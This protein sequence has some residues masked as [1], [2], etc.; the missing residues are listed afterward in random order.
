MKKNKAPLAEKPVQ[1]H[2]LA[3]RA[4]S[5]AVKLAI[6]D[7]APARVAVIDNP[8][9]VELVA[10]RDFAIVPKQ[11]TIASLAPK[12]RQAVVCSINGAYI[13]RSEWN[14]LV[15]PG[16]IVLFQVLP[17][18]GKG[19][20]SNP[21]RAILQIGLMIGVAW[22]VGP[23]ALGLTGLT[24]QLATAGLMA[25]GS[26]L[27]NKLVPLPKA[28]AAADGT[29]ASPTYSVAMQGNS[30]RIDSPKPVMYGLNKSFPDQAIPPYYEFVGNEQ[31]LKTALFV[32]M[33]RFDIREVMID[34]TPISN[35]SDINMLIVGPGRLSLDTQQILD[36]RMISSPE[37]SGQEVRDTVNWIG[38]FTVCNPGYKLAKLF[39]DLSA[40]RGIG[41]AKDD[42]TLEI[43]YIEFQVQCQKV[44]NQGKA[45][46][47]W[48]DLRDAN[49]QNYRLTGATAS[50]VQQS[51]EF[52]FPEFA[53][54]QVRL[55]RVTP[56]VDST[57]E[58]TEL[59]WVGMRSQMTKPGIV[60][61]ADPLGTYILL[62]IRAS[63]QLSGL[64]SR[65]ISVISERK[66]Q[67]HDGNGWVWL[68]DSPHHRYAAWAI[69]D[70]LRN[71]HYGNGLPDSKIDMESIRA[72]ATSNALRQDR[73]DYI[74]DVR[75]TI[76]DAV[77]L[78]ARTSR[79]VPISR[80]ATYSFVR[81]EK[82]D[83][84][85]AMFNP[86]NIERGSLSM[87]FTF[88]D[89]DPEDAVRVTYRDLS[90]F[91]P[92]TVVAQYHDGVV[93]AYLQDDRPSALPAPKKYAN[94]QFP[95]ISGYIHACREAIYIV[96][97]GRWRRQ[98][99]TFSTDSEGM[100]PAFGSLIVL[101]H[102]L[103]RTA[104]HA[105]V[106]EYDPATKTLQTSQAMKWTDGAQ[107]YVRLSTKTGGLTNFIAVAKGAANDMMVLSQEP[108]FTVVDMRH[109][110]KL[111]TKMM[112]GPSNTKESSLRVTG[113]RHK[114]ENSIELMNLVEDDRVHDADLALLPVN[115]APQD[116]VE[117]GML[118]AAVLP[119]NNV[120]M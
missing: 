38:P 33:G 118:Q 69:C 28:G 101:L 119:A 1:L 90:T 52:T 46:G 44:N 89:E 39:L 5:V 17:H 9:A 45:I 94:V 56:Y 72:L 21:L 58:L 57:R 71:P 7:F 88:A 3:P 23:A 62:S 81:D 79:A 47:D 34:D 49:N 95:G 60:E 43:R 63:K 24:A 27:I 74:F 65:R 75:S 11:A 25:L 59:S 18:G 106:Y 114:G 97:N 15:R 115:G 55:K 41:Y 53:R 77:A 91:A 68:A 64:S 66:I 12:T 103:P 100:L 19:G 30:A 37:V 98:T 42:G 22:L 99:R 85:V 87:G 117:Y 84:P 51:F 82:Q 111:P 67:M 105:D 112:F 116:L 10:R 4:V 13:S 83:A 93:H 26:L 92:V 76:W 36:L 14:T 20:G 48:I 6:A 110:T 78:A 16:E 96:A 104:Q 54:Y 107:H 113:I 86:R 102:D 35:F 109:A 120:M 70:M 73:F 40:P 8:F 80:R 31:V 108:G 50:A 2:D 32:G 61:P 29:G